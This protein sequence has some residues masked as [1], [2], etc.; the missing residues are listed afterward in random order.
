MRASATAADAR[1]EPSAARLD[2]L[3][4][5]DFRNIASAL[6]TFPPEGVAIVGEN[7]QGKTNLIEAIAYFRLMRSQRGARDRDL[8]RFDQPAFHLEMQGTGTRAHRATAA[9]DR[10][11]RK[12]VTLDG[13][14]TEKLTDALDTVPSVSFSPRDVDLV[15]GAPAERRRYLD[16]ALALT[17]PAYLNA[18][19]HYRG[20]LSRRNAAMRVAARATPRGGKGGDDLASVAAWEPALAEHGATLITHRRAWVAE[21]AAE[22]ARHCTAIGERGAASL[23]YDSALAEEEDP[24]AA[25]R[26]Q[27]ERQREH[28]VR[29]LITHAGPHRDDLALAI[30]GH[31]LRTIGSA[32]QQR[33]AAIVLRLLEAATHREATGVTPIL[34]LDDPFAELD[35]RRTARILALLESLG[36]G[37]CVLCVPREDEIPAQYTRLPRWSV[38]D[39]V[40]TDAAPGLAP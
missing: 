13:G 19:R 36:T 21:R 9:V 30:D 38:R 22:F 37:Q 39:G 16:I 24:R 18:L 26:A 32:G 15:A 17:S 11:G 20:A 35:R 28:D 31:D 23:R 3:A 1:A 14:E 25:L 33:T 8:I 34:L 5:R 6:L 4:V 10:G 40:F 12:K 27:L 2:A 7:G 29:R